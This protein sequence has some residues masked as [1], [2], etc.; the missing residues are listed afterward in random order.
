MRRPASAPQGGAR[1]QKR[2]DS[3]SGSSRGRGRSE[4]K[5]RDALK[6]RA[7]SDDAVR[8]IRKRGDVPVA[9]TPYWYNSQWDE[10][11]YIENLPT[12][13]ETITFV[14]LDAKGAE[15]GEITAKVD[16]VDAEGENREG[17]RALLQFLDTATPEI[18]DWA[19]DFFRGGDDEHTGCLHFCRGAICRKEPSR[20]LVHCTPGNFFNHHPLRQLTRS[21]LVI[22]LLDYQSLKAL[23]RLITTRCEK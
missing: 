19:K 6:R 15:L 22:V 7:A 11:A 18:A 14:P 1:R 12:P 20:R 3:R 17:C 13:A 23:V 4:S 5:D 16:Y 2:T 8:I 10:H 9:R 21:L